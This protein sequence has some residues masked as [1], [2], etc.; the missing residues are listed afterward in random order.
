MHEH[1][2]RTIL[3]IQAVEDSDTKGEL[4]PL[5]EREEA[6][7][8]VA[9]GDGGVQE[10]FADGLLTLA[11]E[12]LLT[13]R[14]LHL[15]E[16]LR[17]RAPIIDQALA[18]AAGSGAADGLQAIALLVGLL[19]AVLDGRGYIDILGW[20]ILGLLAWNLFV[21]VLL[22]A[23]WLRPRRWSGTGVAS[24]YAR[25]MGSRAGSVLKRS[26]SFNV[27][28]AAALPRFSTDWGALSRNLVMQRARRIFHV[29]AALVAVG[30][31][32]GLFIRGLVLRD[33]A[34]W[35]SSF[36]G[37]GIVRACLKLLYAP[38]AAILGIALPSGVQDVAA[39]RVTDAGGGVAPLAWL[40][41][42]TL[43]VTLYIIAPRLL[44]AALA[45]VRLWIIARRMTV[46]A[47][48]V[49]YARRILPAARAG[50]AGSP[51]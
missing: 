16:R 38:A 6:T 45:G 15:Y 3:F 23:N 11:G 30:F 34:G 46:P 47:S 28:L 8:S 12:R 24:L 33:V 19:L 31:I 5:A 29:C 49:P 22:V 37:A 51:L 13:R 4:L 27:P 40:D 20:S 9:G 39:L 42:G 41:L 21:Y 14:A 44:A 48:V 35:Q 2:L 10:V 26:R 43:T 50:L 1:A 17:L 7:Q 32:A 36:L 18:V 25:W